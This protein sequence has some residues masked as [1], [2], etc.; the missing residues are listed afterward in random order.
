[1]KTILGFT[2]TLPDRAAI[3][4]TCKKFY[5][6][7]FRP[8]V[9]KLVSLKSVEQDDG[10]VQKDSTVTLLVERLLTLAQ[11]GNAEALLYLARIAIYVENDMMVGASLLM[12]AAREGNYHAMHELAI[13]LEGSNLTGE[14]MQHQFFQDAVE[15]SCQA[16]LESFMKSEERGDLTMQIFECMA[17][18]RSVVSLNILSHKVYKSK[19]RCYNPFCFRTAPK[20][21][22]P[23]TAEWEQLRTKVLECGNKLSQAESSAFSTGAPCCLVCAGCN[24]R[25]Y[26][27]TACSQ[28]GWY[29]HKDECPGRRRRRH[30]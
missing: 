21:N 28:L 30:R 18:M 3:A 16:R 26:C 29:D 23:F 7:S 15:G 27:S 12:K 14:E 6:F 4:G 10:L 19:R 17:E 20:F 9:L 2:Q 1:M 13:V 22:K 11:A 24:H 25:R 8:H 5:E